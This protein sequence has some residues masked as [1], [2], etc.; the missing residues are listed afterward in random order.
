MSNIIIH[1][2][3]YPSINL[4]GDLTPDDIFNLDDFWKRG[5]II[6]EHFSQQNDGSFHFLIEIQGESYGFKFTPKIGSEIEFL[7]QLFGDG[8]TVSLDIYRRRL[9]GFLMPRVRGVSV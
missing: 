6:A 9:D 8:R 4:E 3:I 1:N 5:D 7:C 2:L